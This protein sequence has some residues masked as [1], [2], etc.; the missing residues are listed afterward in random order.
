MLAHNAYAEAR[1]LV[2]RLD[3][4]SAALKSE[5]EAM[6]PE[7]AARR[8]RGFGGGRGGA[9]GAARRTLES[10]SQAA[11]AAAM[12]MQGADVTPTAGQIAAAAK[13]RADVRALM[14]QWLALKARA[15]R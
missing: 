13:A 11:M 5:I 2:A 12:A 10:V 4:A 8:P 14:Q 6:A 7:T 1:A 9:A 3:R 15:G